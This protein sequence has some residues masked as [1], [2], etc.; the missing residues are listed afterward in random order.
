[1]SKA[2]Q[3][4]IAL[5]CGMKNDSAIVRDLL[6]D[7][8]ETAS[9]MLKGVSVTQEDLFTTVA[10]E[11]F[12]QHKEFWP[13][14]PDI[15]RA[16]RDG[17]GAI[18]AED[19]AGKAVS[20]NKT[21]LD[22]AVEKDTLKHLFCPEIWKGK[23]GE[24]E[25]AWFSVPRQSRDPQ[26][27][28]D[29]RRAVAA[30]SGEETRQDVLD[31]M[32]IAVTAIRRAVQDGNA[33]DLN[34]KLAAEGDQLRIEDILMPDN[35]GDHALDT[36]SA[37]TQFNALFEVIEANGEK[38]ESRHF[39][40]KHKGKKSPL[41][42]ALGY[43]EAAKI[44]SPRVWRGRPREMMELF[45]HVPVEKRAGLGIEGVL[46]EIE[47]NL[48]AEK[49][50]IGG[51]LCKGRLT[52][53][54]N[55]AANGTDAAPIRGICLKKVWDNIGDVRALLDARGE[56]L[57]LADLRLTS[58]HNQATALAAA[59]A[60]GAFSAVMEI[61]DKNGE[62]LEVSDLTAKDKAGASLLSI[63]I[64][65]NELDRA[66][67]PELWAHRPADFKKL[68]SEMPDRAKDKIDYQDFV[69]RMNLISL[70]RKFAP[71]DRAPAP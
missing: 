26:L 60:H 2:G 51:G 55:T 22:F 10:G 24:M 52:E 35:D 5:M 29:L 61:L 23:T 58:G 25:K 45:S 56:S 66:V 69:S 54:M 50:D 13:V 38:F 48:C 28:R 15:V 68:W 6:A 71:P 21:P 3:L 47:E 57:T 9:S 63:L 11:T 34:K 31:R 1:M 16:I 62:D 41:E 8:A 14:L 53:T 20:N 30:A 46:K 4:A 12:F 64:T 70:R 36:R 65:R 18:G 19:F 37:W 32:G 33:R 27:F 42:E 59:A 7:P 39:L 44:F 67:K 17:G 40:H 43:G 49:I